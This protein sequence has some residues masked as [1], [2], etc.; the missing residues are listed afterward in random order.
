MP[1]SITIEPTVNKWLEAARLNQHNLESAFGQKR[2][3]LISKAEVSEFRKQ[4]LARSVEYTNSELGG[5]SSN[6]SSSEIIIAAGHQ[7]VIYHPGVLR[8]NLALSQAVKDFSVKGLNIII[9]TDSGD[10]GAFYYPECIADGEYKVSIDSLS[11]GGDLFLSQRIKPEVGLKEVFSKL[12]IDIKKIND[13]H[14]YYKEQQ[15]LSAI[16]ANAKYR[17]SFEN[18][19]NYTEILLSE[20]ISLPLAQKFYLDILSN[21]AEFTNFFNKELDLFRIKRKIKNHANP[22]PNLEVLAEC[23]ELPFWLI[24]RKRGTRGPLYLRTSDNIYYSQTN[25]IGELRDLSLYLDW[26]QQGDFKIA[27]RAFL[28]TTLLRLF[29]SD[30]FLH[31]LGGARYDA[32]LDIFFENYWQISAPEYA[33]VSET[34]SFFPEELTKLEANKAL[35]AKARE[36]QFRL[37]DYLGAGIFPAD[38][39]QQLQVSWQNRQLLVKELSQLKEQKL[40]AAEATQRL[41][42]VDA[43]IKKLLDQFFTTIRLP[44]EETQRVYE[45][46]EFPYF[47]FDSSQFL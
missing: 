47:I 37:G 17:R 4:L 41:K 12:P 11:A 20:L 46:R 15:G 30:Y 38:L 44:S 1:N 3:S 39:E 6:N 13:L 42:K 33:V 45:F 14:E 18:K 8:K 22:F 32:F 36:I 35:L 2:L 31:G 23:T 7:P 26:N 9:D 27:P 21:A 29:V 28:I 43:E 10:A 19:P 25:E 16:G 34:K 40:S 5:V 24:N